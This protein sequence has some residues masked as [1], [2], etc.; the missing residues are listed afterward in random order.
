MN[1]TEH[2]NINS[3]ILLCCHL[4]FTELQNRVQPSKNVPLSEKK[5]LEKQKKKFPKCKNLRV[6]A[7]RK[8]AYLL[9]FNH[10]PNYF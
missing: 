8:F 7:H 5:H 1:T 2:A 9:S 10:S 4:N 3:P 6:V